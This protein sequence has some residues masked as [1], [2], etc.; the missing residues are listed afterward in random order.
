[1]KARVQTADNRRTI[2]SSSS[3]DVVGANRRERI[4]RHLE[5]VGMNAEESHYQR[6]RQQRL[7]EL[8]WRYEVIQRWLDGCTT[9]AE[10]QAQLQEMLDLVKSELR[11]LAA[12]DT[13][14]EGDPNLKQ[15]A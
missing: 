4:G 15:S 11:A 5:V 6:S 8:R 2:F 1:M 3:R 13:V 14:H 12:A 10:S 9:S 7:V